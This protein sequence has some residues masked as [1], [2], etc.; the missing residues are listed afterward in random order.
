MSILDFEKKVNQLLTK[1]KMM[2]SRKIGLQAFCKYFMAFAWE[3]HSRMGDGFE[4][5]D[6]L[7]DDDKLIGGDQFNSNFVK[8]FEELYPASLKGNR[9]WQHL[10]PS[11]VAFKGKGLGVGELYLALVIQGWSFE[12]TDG[13]GDG[14]VAGGIRELKNTGAS[15]KPLA[16]AVRVQDHLNKTVFKGNRAGPV[17]RFD[18][19]QAWIKQEPNA[20]AVYFE[21]FRQLYP[22]RDVKDMAKKLA[23]AKTGREFYDII[24][25]EVLKWYK[26]V[27]NW[28]SLVIIDQDKMRIANIA[29]VNNLSMFTDLK[30]DWKSERGGDTQAITDGYVNIKI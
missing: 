20:E 16:E 15:L 4:M 25:K 22:G 21:Y 14:R 29:D 6:I 30:F 12:R 7:I 2:P 28:N 26:T 1:R 24:G 19:H 17:S 27:D 8:K 3:A 13:K 9:S 10:M 18:E 23:A 5:L 11:L